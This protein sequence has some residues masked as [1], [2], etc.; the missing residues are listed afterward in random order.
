MPECNTAM[1]LAGIGGGG[2]AS[3]DG[4]G[5]M[6]R[7]ETKPTLDSFFKPLNFMP[8]RNAMIELKKFMPHR[9][10]VTN[11]HAFNV[12]GTGLTS[13]CSLSLFL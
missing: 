11:D 2:L 6:S 4:Q 8:L 5:Q 10:G 3:F 9:A 7:P 12:C 1:T 13:F